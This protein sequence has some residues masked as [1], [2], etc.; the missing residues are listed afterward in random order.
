EEISMA[1]K[2]QI[3]RDIDSHMQKY[4]TSNSGW[5]VGI[6]T[7]AKQR[8]FVDHRVDEKNGTWIYAAADTSEIA[9]EI[10]K[11]YHDAGCKGGPG[12]GDYNTR[13][14]YAYVITSSTVE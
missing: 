11:A 9:R 7:D 1:T 3:I 13:M 6:A 10:E 4:S 8:L 12:G 2:Q 5:Y 14:V